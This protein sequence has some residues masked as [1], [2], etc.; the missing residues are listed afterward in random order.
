MGAHGLGSRYNF[1]LARLGVAIADIIPDGGGE[2]KRVLQYQSQLPP[3]SD[4]VDVAKVIA[5]DQ[6]AS[7]GD[8]IKAGDEAYQGTLACPGRT[9]Y[10]HGLPRQNM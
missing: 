7:L 3:V 9:H 1:I 4:L 8:I 2:K 10:G 6:N 5:I